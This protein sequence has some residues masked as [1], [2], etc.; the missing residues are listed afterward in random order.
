MMIPGI[1]N[2]SNLRDKS[3]GLGGYS[4]YRVTPD[5]ILVY[6]HKIGQEPKK[7]G[8]YSLSKKYYNEDNS[9][10]KRPSD[11]VNHIYPQVKEK[12]ITNIGNTIYSSPVVYQNK[13]YVGDD[14]GILSCLALRDGKEIWRFKTNNR[15]VGT[16][17]VSNDIVVFGSADKYIYGIHA[18]TGKQ[19]WKYPAKE[20]VLGA[21][22][23]QMEL[24][25]LG[26]VTI[27]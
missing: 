26:L 8:G 17:A 14:S 7:W 19:I 10:Y 6:E 16:P 9:I 13:V 21:V 4:L 3:D 18:N 2:R 27:R 22:T 12:W 20:A 25:I 24:L 11:S 15:I 5:S 23:I 1:L